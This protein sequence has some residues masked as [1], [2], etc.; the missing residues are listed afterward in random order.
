MRKLI[1]RIYMLD[2]GVE[3]EIKCSNIK[4]QHELL[5]TLL[6]SIDDIKNSFEVKKI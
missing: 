3:R 6:Q 4:E 2:D 5:V 1:Y